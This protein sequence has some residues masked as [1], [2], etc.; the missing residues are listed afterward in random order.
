MTKTGATLGRRPT[1]NGALLCVAFLFLH[2]AEA[3]SM[4]QGTRRPRE[5][6]LAASWS[7]SCSFLPGGCK[8]RRTDATGSS[9]AGGA[10]GSASDAAAASATIAEQGEVVS[11]G[12]S[13]SAAG[14]A[15]AT[16]DAPSSTEK[17]PG[18]KG[19]PLQYHQI[20]G[21][22]GDSPRCL[23]GEPAG[24]FTEVV[25]DKE[26]LAAKLANGLLIELEGGGW[27][28]D[29]GGDVLT[30]CAER[31]GKTWKTGET[32]YGSAVPTSWEQFDRKAKVMETVER[33]NH[34]RYAFKDSWA[35]RFFYV[36]VPYCDG[37]AFTGDL[38]DPVTATDG[39]EM[40]FHG[41]RILDSVMA[42]LADRFF[43]PPFVRTIETLPPKEEAVPNEYYLGAGNGSA[44]RVILYGHSAGG[45]ATFYAIDRVN[46]MLQEYWTAAHQTPEVSMEPKPLVV[47]G[48][49]QSGFFVQTPA[50]FGDGNTENVFGRSM[51]RLMEAVNGYDSLNDKCLQ[52]FP[53]DKKK[54]LHLQYFGDLLESPMFV[55]QSKYDQS[56]IDYF[57]TAKCA[58]W[59]NEVCVN[60]QVPDSIEDIN[61]YDWLPA[62][63]SDVI[64]WVQT[65]RFPGTQ[66]TNIE[67]Q[68]WKNSA[69][70]KRDYKDW[71]LDCCFFHELATIK[72][73][74]QLHMHQSEKMTQKRNERG[75]PQ[76]SH[77]YLD[78]IA[79]TVLGMDPK[80]PS[81]QVN[82]QTM[83]EAFVLWGM[84]ENA[85][86]QVI[87]EKE[88][89][90]SDAEKTCV[91]AP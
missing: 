40:H 11:A 31:A 29:K 72:N 2:H 20:L 37:T 25:D 4:N 9:G 12:A 82:G 33:E 73:L 74:F 17:K 81:S 59:S 89:K 64:K 7:W 43:A 80:H 52:K 26:K 6:F 91:R 22:N 56:E 3:L 54:C 67:E 86:V 13:S 85:V 66:S 62:T 1:K 58:F 49:S 47:R 63:G 41:K 88:W 51:E 24:Y 16:A 14:S 70:P 48:A 44:A 36:Y 71:N 28:G 38:K 30:D 87:D 84:D 39:T 46:A 42:E 77:F 61:N 18:Y 19:A 35:E 90:P 50:V 78:C 53:D 23:N 15:Q 65:F 10:V 68:W 69:N 34:T 79:H 8:R 57:L 60:P 21:K 45:L 55:M 76:H 5:R 32:G 75:Q 83:D 27:C